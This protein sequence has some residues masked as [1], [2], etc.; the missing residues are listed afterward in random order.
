[1]FTYRVWMEIFFRKNIHYKNYY[2][3]APVVLRKQGMNYFALILIQNWILCGSCVNMSLIY[4]VKEG[5]RIKLWA[6]FCVFCW[7][8]N[9]RGWLGRWQ[10]AESRVEAVPENTKADVSDE[11]NACSHTSGLWTHVQRGR[12]MTPRITTTL[13]LGARG[14]W[15]T[16]AGLISLPLFPP[17]LRVL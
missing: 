10:Q 12:N 17:L 1:M 9:G 15:E 13:K 6:E 16:W 7:S 4:G 14:P 3:Y 2:R 5:Q 11:V 8:L